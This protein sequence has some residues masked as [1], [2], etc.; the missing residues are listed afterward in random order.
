MKKT[1]MKNKWVFNNL[2]GWILML[3]IG[4][5]IGSEAQ[6]GPPS[7]PVVLAA[8]DTAMLQHAPE[9]FDKKRENI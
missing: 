4:L 5:T 1:G 2:K 8:D 6:P 9:G 7:G 3:F